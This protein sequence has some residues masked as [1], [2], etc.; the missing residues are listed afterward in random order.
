MRVADVDEAAVAAVL[1]F[2]AATDPSTGAVAVAAAG[3]AAVKGGRHFVAVAAA[4]VWTSH[5]VFKLAV[6][7][8]F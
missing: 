5:A 4:V 6:G 2:A 1:S 8:L 7:R 3:A